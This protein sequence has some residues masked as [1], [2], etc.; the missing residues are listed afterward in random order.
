MSYKDWYT[1]NSAPGGY[2]CVA[3]DAD[4]NFVKQYG[5]TM[6]GPL[7]GNCGCFAGHTMCRHKKMVVLFQQEKKVGTRWY[8]NF[9]RNKW[10]APPNDTTG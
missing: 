2:T 5:I 4:L 10:K 7:T 6:E 9:D 3:V 1:I 8:Y